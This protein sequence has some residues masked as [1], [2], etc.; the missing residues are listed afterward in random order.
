VERFARR[1][2]GTWVLTVLQGMDAVLR[3]ES[4]EAELTLADIYR[5]VDFQTPPDE[6]D[7]ATQDA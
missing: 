6:K 1:D 5:D 3:F 2:D 4:I 7:A